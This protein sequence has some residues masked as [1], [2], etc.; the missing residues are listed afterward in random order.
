M[1]TQSVGLLAGALEPTGIRT[2]SIA[3]LRHVAERVRIPRALA[4]PF[5]F[6]QPLGAEG[7]TRQH[8]VVSRALEL[9]AR[10]GPIVEDFVK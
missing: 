8:D 10:P 4:V 2:V 7:P 6:G 9:L 3:L 5:P 1:C